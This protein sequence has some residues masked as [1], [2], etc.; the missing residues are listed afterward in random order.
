LTQSKINCKI[1]LKSLFLLKFISFFYVLFDFLCD[2]FGLFLRIIL[3]LFF[4]ILTK[5]FN[6]ICT[7]FFIKID[8]N[9]FFVPLSYSLWFIEEHNEKWKSSSERYF[10]HSLEKLIAQQRKLWYIAYES[11]EK[12]PKKQNKSLIVV[13]NTEYKV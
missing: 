9:Q 12:V 3:K 5:N 6:Y 2:S 11:T 8:F 4:Q 10:A 13:T 1:T 7:Q